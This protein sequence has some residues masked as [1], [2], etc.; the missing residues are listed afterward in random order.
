MAD[1]KD[2]EKKY[3]PVKDFA[4]K[5]MKGKEFS[6]TRNAYATFMASQLGYGEKI[7][8]TLANHAYDP[9]KV[10]VPDQN[11][12]NKPK[13]LAN[14][15]WENSGEIGNRYL[16]ESEMRGDIQ[17]FMEV[18][19]QN[20]TFGELLDLTGNSDAKDR[21]KKDYQNKSVKDVILTKDKQEELSKK[22]NE[23]ETAE[24]KLDIKEKMEK[25]QY[26]TQIYQQARQEV[27]NYR[28]VQTLK[29][30]LP[31]AEKDSGKNLEKLLCEDKKSE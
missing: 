24:E 31:K 28:I 27:D 20:M 16:S 19:Y 9:W 14:E 1:E 17:Q 5:I 26:N 10:Q 25:L 29:E 15:K 11:N 21:L 4:D 22:Y 7:K 8:E 23:A 2:S 18:A 6:G 30:T 12:E 3:D 13:N